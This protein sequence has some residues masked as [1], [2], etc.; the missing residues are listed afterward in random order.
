M[1][2]QLHACSAE[3]VDQHHRETGTR[4][5]ETDLAVGIDDDVVKAVLELE[6]RLWVRATA[7]IQKR[8]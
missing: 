3:L 6:R 1:P 8:S 4:G 2:T 5:Q 7:L